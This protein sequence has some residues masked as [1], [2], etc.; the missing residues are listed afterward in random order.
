MLIM[1]ITTLLVLTG[2]ISF[3]DKVITADKLPATAGSFIDRFFHEATVSNVKKDSEFFKT[4]Y[5]VFLQDGTEIEFNSKGEWE[6]VDGKRGT[7]PAGLIPAAVSE[8]VQ[9]SFPGQNIVTIHKEKYGYKIELANELGLKFD[10]NGKL[11]SV[12]G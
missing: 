1:I 4:H 3:K 7:I 10:K 6:K 11:F 5:K 2:I 8:Y 9:S 12:D